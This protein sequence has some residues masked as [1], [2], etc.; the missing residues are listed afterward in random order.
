MEVRW[1][2]WKWKMNDALTQLGLGY[3]YKADRISPETPPEPLK[4]D[5]FRNRVG[6]EKL[7]KTV[8]AI[9]K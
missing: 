2:K 4:G 9:E 7:V 6:K 1:K 8:D 3:N 5:S